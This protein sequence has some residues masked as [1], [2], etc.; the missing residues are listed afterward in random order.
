MTD[1]NRG[2]A[3][4]G[5]ILWS[6]LFLRSWMQT[7]ILDSLETQVDLTIYIPKNS[8]QLMESLAPRH[9]T[10]LLNLES[11]H[12]D[13]FVWLS[14]WTRNLNRSSSFRFRLTRWLLGDRLWFKSGDGT[15]KNLK[16]LI[17]G[18]GYLLKSLATSPHLLV[19]LLPPIALASSKV[20]ATWTSRTSRHAVDVDQLASN[21]IV[22]VASL[23]QEPAL[24]SL[25]AALSRSNVPY[26]FA[27]DN[28]D[29]LSSKIIF[30]GQEEFVT[31]MGESAVDM[32]A[33]IHGLPRR[34]F[35]PFGL[36][37]LEPY[38]SQPNLRKDFR[39]LKSK[40]KVLY[41]GYSVAHDEMESVNSLAR[42]SRK[43]PTP[44]QLRYRPHPGG[45]R[46][47]T[48]ASL[49]LEPEIELSTT[50][51]SERLRFGGL[52]PLTTSYFDDLLW[53]DVVVG[54]P[55][56]MLL[57]S[58]VAGRPIVLDLNVRGNLR[59]SPGITAQK[60]EH[61]Q[62]LLQIPGI[63]TSKSAE[64]MG[65]CIRKVFSGESDLPTNTEISRLFN[66]KDIPYAA[67]LSNYLNYKYAG[68]R[69]EGYLGE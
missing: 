66:T 13:Y 10:R 16:S 58:L 46:Q 39:P 62:E 3:K 12:W 55:T 33:K 24:D 67:A 50:D 49:R 7:G 30:S 56:T 6:P 31:V 45:P 60:Y 11:S 68:S 18:L 53:A 42:L 36:P 57:E 27:L 48:E 37:R 26:G 17:L 19:L 5:L 52:P 4:V 25:L 8:N 2:K 69:G 34:K 59:T 54:P 1:L 38:R 41:A 20:V 35:L 21:D 47:D 63:M 15:R 29:N 22:V 28:W 40:L 32:G 9:S 64:A 44:F 61:I 65:E 43:W 14:R 23:A 51:D